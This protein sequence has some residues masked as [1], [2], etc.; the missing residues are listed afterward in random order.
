MCGAAVLL[1]LLL[2]C[3]IINSRR[4]SALKKQVQRLEAALQQQ[5]AEK[6]QFNK[7]LLGR[8][9]A[10]AGASEFL[11]KSLQTQGRRQEITERNVRSL[12]DGYKTLAGQLQ[13]LKRSAGELRQADARI[14]QESLEQHLEQHK[15]SLE[16]AR[17]RQSALEKA[18]ETARENQPL[19]DASALLS[20]GLSVDEV[21]LKTSLPRNE[22]E[23]LNKMRA[24]NTQ[25]HPLQQA[26][27]A[28]RLQGAPPAA[29]EIISAAVPPAA[30]VSAATM[31]AEARAALPA[32][33]SEYPYVAAVQTAPAPANVAAAV[34]P[35]AAV[36][37]AASASTVAPAAPAPVSGPVAGLKA[38][39][40]YGMPAK[41]PGL[42]R[43]R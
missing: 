16:N 27:P 4:C 25:A 40:A 42:R 26:V 33:G 20:Q 12:R 5:G 43:S 19:V 41:T 32:A 35:A 13:T 6:Q 30:A 3:F 8:L 7:Q 15:S 2:V 38:R 29:A 36:P 23:I 31:P 14:I 18:R 11:Q 9:E 1:L 21:S 37:A 24:L 17:E 28:P 10:V 22:V 39:S 34:V